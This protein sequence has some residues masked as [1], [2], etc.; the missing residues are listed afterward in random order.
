MKF[1]NNNLDF[2]TEDFLKT[3]FNTATESWV[4]TDSKGTIVMINPITEKMFGYTE[5]ELLGKKIEVLMPETDRRDHVPLRNSYIK[6]PRK[7]PHGIGV[8]VL[9]LRKDN[10]QFPVEI[11]LNYYKTG[12]DTYALA[13]IIDIT[14]RRERDR[15]LREALLEKEQ[16]KREK[17]EAELQVLKNQVSPHYFF[18]SLSVLVPLI[19]IDS[20][21]AQQFVE[22]LAHSY[23]Y[24][25]EIRD[26]L[27]VT[28]EEELNFIKDYEYLQKVRFKDKF[29]IQYKIDTKDLSQRILPFSVQ[30]LIENVFKHN[31]LYKDNKLL[32]EVGTLNGG[33]QIKNNVIKRINTEAKSLGIGLKN[34]KKQYEYITNNN[35]P[36]FD[37]D[38]NTYKAWIPFI[39]E[40]S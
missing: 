14:L 23:R 40:K 30:I 27:T 11:S 38:E 39:K 1:A 13:V 18:N 16:L 5:D 35:R 32:I 22:K 7:R 31:A 6:H 37:S 12:N 24:I 20:H 17:I 3:I 2:Y 33:I 29:D 36:I 26:K 8:E 4:L 28:L 21:T 34:I 25:L 10:S 9:G 15:Q 19:N